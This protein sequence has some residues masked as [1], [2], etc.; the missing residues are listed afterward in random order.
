MTTFLSEGYCESCDSYFKNCRLC[1]VCY[2]RLEMKV[3]P[4]PT[5]EFKLSEI[6]EIRQAIDIEKINTRLFV[7]ITAIIQNH[8]TN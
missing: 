2:K 8:E 3:N 6:K 5:Y 4:D 7:K 1:P